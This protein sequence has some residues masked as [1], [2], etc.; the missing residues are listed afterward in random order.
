MRQSSS[1]I[2]SV[3]GRTETTTLLVRQYGRNCPS[4]LFLLLCQFLV[5]L[6]GQNMFCLRLKVSRSQSQPISCSNM[7]DW[8]SSRTYQNPQSNTWVRVVMK[9]STSG[10]VV[11]EWTN[12]WH[13]FKGQHKR[14]KIGRE[15]LTWRGRK[16]PIVG[17]DRNY[18]GHCFDLFPN[19]APTG[20]GN[21][22]IS[23]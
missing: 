6:H 12:G 9:C 14:I 2:D 17:V 20:T 8:S 11:F 4:S 19:F 5:C 23:F 15:E 7:A 16:I 1:W 13:Y 3:T 22:N 10:M 18:G 21:D